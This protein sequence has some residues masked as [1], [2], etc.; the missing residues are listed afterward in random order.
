M[1]YGYDSNFKLTNMLFEF[2]QA[3]III[4]L[5]N[6]VPQVGNVDLLQLPIRFIP[7]N[8]HIY[9]LFKNHKP[10]NMA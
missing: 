2:K 9:F 5:N 1:L 10:D 4:Y 7:A 6:M 3:N 8:K